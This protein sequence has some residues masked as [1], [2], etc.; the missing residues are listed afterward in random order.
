VH[1]TFK[2]PVAATLVVL[3]C[4]IVGTAVLP[5]VSLAQ[6]T[7]LLVLT[8]FTLVNASLIVIKRRGGAHPGYITVPTAVPY[9]GVLLCTGTIAFQILNW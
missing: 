1:R 3:C 7:S 4:M 2:T 8:I 5:L 6:L 9:L